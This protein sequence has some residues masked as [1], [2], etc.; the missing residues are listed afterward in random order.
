VSC[1][2][3]ISFSVQSGLKSEAI[4]RFPLFNYKLNNLQRQTFQGKLSFLSCIA[5]QRL[6]LLLVCIY[7]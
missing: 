6:S 4:F 3:R 1:G 5:V 7:I 2:L